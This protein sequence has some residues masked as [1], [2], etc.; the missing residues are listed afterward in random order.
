MAAKIPIY[1]W[2]DQVPDHLKTRNQLGELGLKPGGPIAARVE[3]DRGKKFAYLYDVAQAV[4]KRPLSTEA[5]A[6]IE[7]D[8]IARR[9][10][11]VCRRVFG[12]VLHGETCLDCYVYNADGTS[13]RDEG[14]WQVERVKPYVYTVWLSVDH[15]LGPYA[16][17]V[18]PESRWY[19]WLLF[20]KTE[21]RLIL[22]DRKF[23]PDLL[24]HTHTW[25]LGRPIND[26]LAEWTI[27]EFAALAAIWPLLREWAID[28][29]LPGDR[30]LPYALAG[31]DRL[32]AAEIKVEWYAR[33]TTY[34]RD[35]RAQEGR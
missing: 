11:P 24:G 35:L 27:A 6:K 30:F 14:M 26:L 21:L 1:P 8:K 4:A 22:S 31:L 16:A 17:P 15:V 7:S 29:S 10:C 13:R 19:G 5:R 33:R 32:D 18:P 12:R 9:T 2:F 23:G 25:F 3:W 34:Y 28:A 20:P